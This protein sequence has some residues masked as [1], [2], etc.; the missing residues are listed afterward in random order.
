MRLPVSDQQQLRPY[1]S[2]FIHNI[3][4]THRQTDGRT[5]KSLQQRAK[6]LYLQLIGWPDRSH[7]KCCIMVC[8]TKVKVK[9]T[10]PSKLKILPFSKS[11][12]TTHKLN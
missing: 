2:Q 7:N 5:D 4:V 10:K 1:L 9:I 6:P 11:L 8:Y 12:P 3:S